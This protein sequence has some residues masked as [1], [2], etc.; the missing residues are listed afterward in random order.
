MGVAAWFP[1]VDQLKGLPLGVAL[2]AALGLLLA[3]LGRD[4][5]RD[6]EPGLFARWGGK[7]TTRLLSHEHSTMN[8]NSLRAIHDRL[9][10]LRPDLVLPSSAAEETQDLE[11]ARAAYESCVDVLRERTRN[12]NEFP[13][14]FEEN[15]S[16]GFRRNL[17]AMRPAGWVASFIGLASSVAALTH[18]WQTSKVLAAFPL[19]YALVCV[20]L[21]VWW[22]MRIKPEWVRLPAEAYAH[23]L[24]ETCL[25]S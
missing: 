13:L 6:S 18:A 20:V 2:T 21:L 10:Q 17:W 16:Y 5:G 23:R 1:G 14:V 3:Q 24:L 25:R 11:S 19:V 7:P 22:S 15:A 12:A 8:P 4:A 9:R